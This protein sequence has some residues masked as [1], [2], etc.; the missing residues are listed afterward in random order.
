MTINAGTIKKRRLV[1]AI[2]I[3]NTVKT[4]KNKAVSGCILLQFFG[5]INFKTGTFL[6]MIRQLRLRF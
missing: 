1:F 3:K 5:F 4:M 6:D 2:P